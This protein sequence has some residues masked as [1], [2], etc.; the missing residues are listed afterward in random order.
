MRI[1]KNNKGITV[2]ELLVT[3]TILALVIALGVPGF[4]AFFKKTEINNAIRTVTSAINTARC[5]AIEK[6]RRVQLSIA[7]S[8]IILKEKRDDQ[9]QPFMDFDAG[10][11]V[12]CTINA[13]PVFYP[14]GYIAP[15]CSIFVKTEDFYYR[16]TISMAGRIKVAKL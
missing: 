1:E 13:L 11:K 3:L 9:W 16:V 15:L 10:E 6:N 12:S 5:Q 2:I 4:K 8:K 14:E 7:G